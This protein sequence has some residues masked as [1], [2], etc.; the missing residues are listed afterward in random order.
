MCLSCLKILEIVSRNFE[1]NAS[2]FLY[3]LEDIFL[4]LLQVVS[5]SSFDTLAR[6]YSVT[7]WYMFAC[8]SYMYLELF[9]TD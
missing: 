2:E 3:N 8:I 7:R 4:S 6:F 5:V 1:A 9:S